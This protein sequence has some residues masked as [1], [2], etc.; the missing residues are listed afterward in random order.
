LR[1]FWR[2]AATRPCELERVV[3]ESV[4]LLRFR[5]LESNYTKEICKQCWKVSG[6]PTKTLSGAQNHTFKIDARGRTVYY[7]CSVIRPAAGGV[8]GFTSTQRRSASVMGH[9]S[10]LASAESWRVAVCDSWSPRGARRLD[11]VSRRGCWPPRVRVRWLTTRGST[12]ARQDLDATLLHK[13]F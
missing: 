6:R 11:R 2:T 5:F 13:R 12:K 7:G 10:P 8:C 9:S 4:R 1:S 3:V